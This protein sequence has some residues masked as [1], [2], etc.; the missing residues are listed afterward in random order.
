[1]SRLIVRPA[2]L[3]HNLIVMHE[4][5]R[6]AGAACMFV[7]KEAPLHP[8]L[9]A[10]ILSG[11][12]VRRLGLVAW[13]HAKLPALP[14]VE[15]CHVY[16]PFPALPKQAA[17]CGCVYVNSRYALR[18]LAEHTDEN[19]PQL[20]LSLEA[21]DGR[22][23]FLPEEL[24]DFCEEVRRSGLRLQG[25]SVNFACLSSE[26][27]TVRRLI[28]ASAV[29]DEIRQ[30]YLPEAD[31][32]AGGTDILELAAQN[33]LPADVR[34]IRC[35]TGVMLGVYPLS[36]NAVPEARQDAFRLEATILECRVKKDRLMALFDVGSFHT[37]P[38]SLTPPFPGMQFVGA[39]SAY[40][41][42]DVTDCP[43]KLTE[44]MTLSFV[45]DYHAL[46]RALC[47]RALPLFM[48]Q[49]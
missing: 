25:L 29:L 34:E 6:K 42:F 3:R 30:L 18:L 15:L 5:C 44:G 43:Q 23:G 9:T 16:A 28:E 37:A 24:P 38:E 8:S 33:P 19:A 27:P 31:I 2:A 1:M 40:A 41:S 45:P 11:S 7:F 36:G 12:P 26:A 4:L 10:D 39:S 20:R 46:S 32:S 47:S 35:G 17:A 13:P 14:G 21:G 48:E 49:A 22:D